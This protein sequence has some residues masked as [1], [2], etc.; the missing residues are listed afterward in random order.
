MQQR[1][2]LHAE[3]LSSGLLLQSLAHEFYNRI[4]SWRTQIDDLEFIA[5][6][7]YKLNILAKIAQTNREEADELESLISGIMTGFSQRAQPTDLINLFKRLERVSLLF[8]KEF[9][10]RICL[11]KPP[12]LSVSI[13][14]SI[15]SLALINLMH[16]TGKHG[17]RSHGLQQRVYWDIKFSDSCKALALQLIVEDNGLGIS[18]FNTKRL[19][20]P[21]ESQAEDSKVRHGIGLWLSRM[22]LRRFK[23]DLYLAENAMGRGC[24]FIIELP[25]IIEMDY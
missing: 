17:N 13:P 21:G 7:P 16:N 23:G 25:L 20:Q 4:A 8:T 18:D 14:S 5:K 3:L 6:N 19:F 15:I 1:L 2:L 10:H 11:V 22:L 24:R 9:G 12:K